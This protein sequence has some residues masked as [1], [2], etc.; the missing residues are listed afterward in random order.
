MAHDTVEKALS[1]QD[2]PYWS[3]IEVKATFIAGAR[4]EELDDTESLAVPLVETKFD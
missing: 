4:L 2:A 1:N 3:S